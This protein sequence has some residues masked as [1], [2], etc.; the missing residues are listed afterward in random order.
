MGRKKKKT[1][2]EVGRPVLYLEKKRAGVHIALVS[3]IHNNGRIDVVVVKA[4]RKNPSVGWSREVVGIP[5]ESER[6]G[7]DCWL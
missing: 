7:G 4:I 2:P 3:R 5:H 6:P 1:I